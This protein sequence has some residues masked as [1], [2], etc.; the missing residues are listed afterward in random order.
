MTIRERIRDFIQANP[1]VDEYDIAEA[2]ELPLFEV[3][4]HCKFLVANQVIK[5]D[6]EPWRHPGVLRGA[7]CTMCK[8]WVV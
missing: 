1:G 3:V 6:R 8:E 4:E 7:F 2:L 5:H